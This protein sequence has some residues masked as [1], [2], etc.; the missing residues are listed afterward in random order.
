MNRHL[1]D[2]SHRETYESAHSVV[3]AIFA[4]HA[5][6]QQQY[7]PGNQNSESSQ[8]SSKDSG[9]ALGKQKSLFGQS[10]ATRMLSNVLSSDNEN[11][12]VGPEGELST[13]TNQ[14]SALSATFVKRMVP[15]YASCLIDVSGISVF[16][17][18]SLLS[19]PGCCLMSGNYIYLIL[20]GTVPLA[21]YRG[22]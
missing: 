12:D 17:S 21:Y 6:R 10:F 18:P 3:L 8:A 11:R 13:I 7:L 2:S 4:S 1:F 20:V 16:V 9:S 19:S 14:E 5:Q 22:S 15:F